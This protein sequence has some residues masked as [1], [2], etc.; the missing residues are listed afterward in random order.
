M[1]RF[2]IS[3]IYAI[4]NAVYHVAAET[5]DTNAKLYLIRLAKE[6]D[7]LAD[8]MEAVKEDEEK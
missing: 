1:A 3:D 2:T 5:R 6:L 4:M 8:E 7:G